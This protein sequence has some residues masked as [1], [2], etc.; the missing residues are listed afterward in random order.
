M[1]SIPYIILMCLF[2]SSCE[3]AIDLNLKDL[4]IKYVIEG[5]ITNEPGV[6]KVMLS[7][8]KDFKDKNTFNGISGAIVKIESDGITTVLP[9]GNNGIYQTDKINGTPGKTYRL[10][11]SI[12]DQVFTASSTMPQPVPF[13]D[14]TL[15]AIDYEPKRVR[16]KVKYKDVASVANYYWF[17]Q[18]VNGKL[19]QRYSVSNDEFTAGQEINEYLLFENT[20]DDESKNIVKGDKLMVEMHSIDAPVYTYLFTLYNA[21]GSANGPAPANPI[22]NISGG[23][24]G[25]FSA[26]TVERKTIVI[27]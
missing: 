17:Q 16:P 27:P 13:L 12:N 15:K 9:E 24:L 7:Q 2:L 18:Y 4:Q 26:H 1:K 10:T 14:F 5:V 20:T 21:N 6:C 19:Q 22:S 8:T 25:F 23:A 11:V 3:D